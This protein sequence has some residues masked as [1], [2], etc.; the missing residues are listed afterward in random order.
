MRTTFSLRTACS[1][2][3]LLCISPAF[4]AFTGTPRVAGHSPRGSQAGSVVEVEFTGSG[5][6]DTRGFLPL[7]T[8]KLVLKR[9]GPGPVAEPAPE[10]P[11]EDRNERREWERRQQKAKQ[12]RDERAKEFS[13]GARQILQLE[14]AADCPPGRH[15]FRVQTNEGLA[16]VATFWV[17]RYPHAAEK[18]VADTTRAETNGTRE[19]AEPLMLNQTLQGVLNGGDADMFRI[20]MKKGA[21]LAVELEAERLCSSDREDGFEAELVVHDAA[22]KEL[23]R[24]DDT[25]LLLTDPWLEV[26]APADGPLYITV[27]PLLP[28]A[29]SRRVPYRLHA[30]SF[31]RPA[32]VYP[33]G[34]PA[35]ALEITLADGTKQ[36]VTLPAADAADAAV[37]PDLFTAG[38]ATWQWRASPETP[39]PNMLRVFPGPNVLETE[40]NDK[41]ETA[42][43]ASVDG[44]VAL[45]GVLSGP[46]DRDHFR[47]RAKKDDRLLVRLFAQGIGS[48]MDAKLTVAPAPGLKDKTERADDSG[49]TDLG[50]FD[51]GTM[52]EKLDPVVSMTAPADGEYI[53]TVEDSRGSGAPEFIYRVEI[54]PAQSG[55][56]LSLAP[57]DR[58]TRLIR[59]A[60]TAGRGN[61]T[62]ATI[63]TRPLPGP[64]VEGELRLTA[65]GLPQ[66]MKMLCD[67]FKADQGRI[68][69]IF[70]AAADAP[71]ACA[72][73]R[74]E[75]TTADGKPVHTLFRHTLPLVTQNNDPFHILT[76]QTLAV[77]VAEQVPFSLEVA[78][79]PGALAKN[80]ETELEVTVKR[81]DGWNEA[82]ELII[83][84]P[85]AGI[86]GAQGLTVP[87]GKDKISFRL[88]A[89]GNARPGTFPIVVTGRNKS[90]DGRTGAG[91][92]FAAS[93]FIPVEVADPWVR[94]KFSRCAIER[95]QKATLTATVERLRDPPGAATLNLLRLPKGVTLTSQPAL[96]G[97]KVVFELE[98]A[99]DALVGSYTGISAEVTVEKDGR[100]VKQLAG[101]ASLRIDPARVAGTR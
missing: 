59:S 81:A 91:K 95:G 22:G 80:G 56:L 58:N 45:N 89:D 40:P 44:P 65:H 96:T 43:A 68:P 54:A 38:A 19:T 51:G 61:R 2:L 64:R 82:V 93:S 88:A 8:D 78:P 13:T 86:V 75:V 15:A 77:A 31:V 4:A 23:A 24:A 70:E 60:V 32:W 46:G 99:S 39:A 6:K 101:Y 87:P 41:P 50:I 84:L 94:L 5:L 97:D 7:T 27:K 62:V 14:V 92:I 25:P 55:M 21:R 16:D 18:E 83:D 69:V 63:L 85:P 37:E 33:A 53:V 10:T 66:G 74:L 30:G 49:D 98:A 35:G 72:K 79:P 47:F 52:R 73:V 71:V 9:I 28:A 12:A 90:G 3:A 48:P 17:S 67:P 29:D 26:T 34:G 76:L 20:E 42:T 57:V 36:T 11:P 100:S 1:G